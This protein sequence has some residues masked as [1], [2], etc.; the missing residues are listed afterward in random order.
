MIL[1]NGKADDKISVHD[2]GFLYGD[3]LFETILIKN[4]KACCLD[5]HLTRLF[6]S[7]D[8]LK[9]KAPGKKTLIAEINDMIKTLDLGVLKIIITRGTGDFS[10]RDLQA[11]RVLQTRVYPGRIEDNMREGIKLKICKTRMSSNPALAGMKLL[12]WLE[13]VLANMELETEYQDGLMLDRDS[14][15]IEGT[16]SNFFCIKNQ[17]IYTPD[18]ATC[19]LPGIMRAKII[20]Y[21]R[22]LG[23]EVK[24]CKIKITDLAN[25]SGFF[26]SNSLGIYP[27]IQIGDTQ[28]QKHMVVQKFAEKLLCG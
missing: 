2:R 12:N 14:F 13:P 19:G 28:Y 5:E 21:A 25:F 6:S 23:F 8:R 26:T 22:S 7:C 1:V 15:V 3:G 9:I 10:A 24:V 18:L 11:N 20:K 27:V 17:V 4:S 16:M